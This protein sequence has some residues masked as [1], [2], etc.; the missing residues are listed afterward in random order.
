MPIFGG[1]RRLPDLPASLR[2]GVATADHQCEA[3]D[4]DCEDVWD[5]WEQRPGL[6][7]RGRATD[8]WHRYP[9]DVARA[10]ELGCTAF[11]FSIAWARVEPRPGEYDD[12]AF[13][14]Y[15]QLIRTIR[16]AGMEPLVTL[17]HFV[18][19]VHVQQRGGLLADD[20]PAVFERYV[21]EVAA[22]LGDEIRYWIPLNE[23]NGL[24][25]GYV[26]PWWE[27]D[28][29]SPP[30]WP[31]GTPLEE[32]LEGVGRVI[33]NL[34]LAH[35]RARATIKRAHPEALVGSNPLPIGLPVL[36]QRL[37]DWNA[38]RLA[39]PQDLLTHGR[40]LSRRP[41]AR[42]AF[43]FLDPL[44][45]IFSILSTGLTS[46]WWHLGMAGR[47]HPLLC[48]KQCIGQQDFVGFDYYWGIS[49][50]RLNKL[51]RLVKAADRQFDQA[52]VWPGGL[53]NVLTHYSRLFPGLPVVI[54]ENGSVDVAD[55]VDRTAYIRR[56]VREVQRA[57]RAGVPVAAYVCWSITSNREWGTSFGKGNDFGLYHIDLDS[58]PSLSRIPTDAIKVLREIIVKRRA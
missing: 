51:K 27:P 33:R 55:G 11:R 22:R 40:R 13:E 8:F 15:L 16:D 56:H 28:Y 7:R 1:R 53:Y 58:D 34:F 6:T 38:T 23:P 45:R 52:P 12:A 57:V 43:S 24:I 42:S 14:H 4:P 36:L 44:L 37:L 39:G 47:L 9:E 50:L 18:W 10:R 48:P 2:F 20:F 5:L 3:Y 30:G 54:C 41:M 19:P 26:K 46:N 17:L 32:Q 21:A 25:Y 35:A 29:A 31:E 49:S